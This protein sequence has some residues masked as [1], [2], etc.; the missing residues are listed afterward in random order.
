[1]ILSKAICTLPEQKQIDLLNHCADT[2]CSQT[3]DARRSIFLHYHRLS[4]NGVADPIS[5]AELTSPEVIHAYLRVIE[6]GIRYCEAH[7]IPFKVLEQHAVVTN[8]TGWYEKD[9]AAIAASSRLTDEHIERVQNIL[10]DVIELVQIAEFTDP[11]HRL[12]YGGMYV[13]YQCT[14]YQSA[15]M[16]FCANKLVDWQALSA[17]LVPIMKRIELEQTLFET[18][19]LTGNRIEAIPLESD[20]CFLMRKIVDHL[21]STRADE[22]QVM[23]LLNELGRQASCFQSNFNH[24]FRPMRRLT[25]CLLSV[26][27]KDITD[28]LGIEQ[29]D[30]QVQM[31]NAIAMLIDSKVLNGREHSEFLSLL[32][33]RKTALSDYSN[34]NGVFQC[35]MD[36]Y[37]AIVK[38]LFYIDNGIFTAE[39]DIVPAYHDLLKTSKGLIL[40]IHDNGLIASKNKQDFYRTLFDMSGDLSSSKGTGRPELFSTIKDIL[41]K[42][43]IDLEFIKSAFKDDVLKESYFN[44]PL[45]NPYIDESQYMDF[46]EWCHKIY[47]FGPEVGESRKTS[48][49]VLECLLKTLVS[50]VLMKEVYPLLLDGQGIPSDRLARLFELGIEFDLLDEEDLNLITKAGS[51]ENICQQTSERFQQILDNRPGANELVVSLLLKERVA[52]TDLSPNSIRA[53][54]PLL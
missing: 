31:R 33:S 51:I 40:E 30:S 8:V 28:N 2:M 25:D 44:I 5:D 18:A 11:N 32:A 26:K 27:A 24:P 38:R 29:I 9:L 35:A 21:E 47:L 45:R 17:L 39:D 34:I 54:R 42:G 10:R 16:A 3:D 53:C 50:V 41:S 4:P 48:P 22:P 43:C 20:H 14:A 36:V 46:I 23:N 7:Q 52:K 6:S 12:N 1:M 49:V 15:F 19:C 37:F 13:N